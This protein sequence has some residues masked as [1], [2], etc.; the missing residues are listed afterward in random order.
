MQLCNP[1]TQVGAEGS[2]VLTI[3]TDDVIPQYSSYTFLTL[4]FV[5]RKLGPSGMALKGHSSLRASA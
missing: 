4:K 3:T 5:C 1:S 2:E